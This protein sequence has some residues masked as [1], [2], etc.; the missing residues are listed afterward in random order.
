MADLVSDEADVLSAL[1]YPDVWVQGDLRL[2][3]TYQFEPGSDADG[4]TVHVPLAVLNRVAPEGF[5]WQVPGLRQELVTALIKS[6][7]KPLRV[8]CVPAPDTRRAVLAVVEPRTPAAA[9]R[10]R[11]RAAQHS[12]ASTSGAEDWQLDKVPD[13]LRMTFRVEDDARPHARRGQGP[14]RR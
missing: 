14:G 10:A 2:P 5:D 7:P 12:S 11:G 3:L 4:V 6:L 8:R 9:R 1:D 13:H